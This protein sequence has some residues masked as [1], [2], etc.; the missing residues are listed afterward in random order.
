MP[1]ISIATVK[2]RPIMGQVD[3]IFGHPAYFPCQNA[4]SK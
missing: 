1:S 3:T 4:V 2:A